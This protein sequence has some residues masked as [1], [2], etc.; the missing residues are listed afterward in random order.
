MKKDKQIASKER[1]EH[2][3]EAIAKIEVFTK[4][5]TKNDFCEN[6]ML[7]NAVL[8]QFHLIGEAIKHVDANKLERYNYPWYRV[9][10][11]RNL[12][13]HE[14]FNIKLEAVWKIVEDHLPEL[15]SVIGEMLKEEL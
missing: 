11:F 4:H 14:Y 10:S 2:I 15:K 7:N 3:Q 8:F 9:R 13:A 1:L 12:I 6:E 5:K